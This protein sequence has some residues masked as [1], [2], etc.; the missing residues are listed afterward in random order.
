[1]SDCE[2]DTGLIAVLAAGLGS[3]FGGGKLDAACG[4]RLLGEWA[5]VAALETGWP[6]AVVAGPGERRF[7]APFAGRVSVIENASPSAGI[8]SSVALAAGAARKAGASAMVLMLADMPLVQPG[9]IRKLAQL[10]R[11]H[12]MSATAWPGGRN[13]VPA[14]FRPGHFDALASLSGDV[15]AQALLRSCPEDALLRLDAEQLSDVDTAADLAGVADLLAA[16]RDCR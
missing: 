12:G 9:S 6:V 13:G 16:R 10:A 8:G 14:C 4:E 1:M 5:V 3:R 15:G 2:E 7:L 11:V